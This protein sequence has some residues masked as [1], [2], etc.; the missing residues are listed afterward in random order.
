MVV[1]LSR[2][3]TFLKTK[4]INEIVRMLTNEKLREE[5]IYI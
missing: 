1:E 3:F 4:E 5:K 2:E